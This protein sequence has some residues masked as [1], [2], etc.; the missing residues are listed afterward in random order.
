[1]QTITL[2]L[3]LHQPTKAKQAV[4]RELAVRV[5]GLANNLV[6][7]GRP[8][9][10]TSKTAKPYCPDRIPSA[11]INQALRDAAAHPKV[12]KFRV[13]WP[14]FNNQN[15]RLERAGDFWTVG[16]PT[17]IGRVR[18]P[19]QATDRQAQLLA[20]LGATVKQGAAKLHEKRGRW[21]LALSISVQVT[22]CVGTKTAGVDLGLRNLAVVNCEGETL[23]FSGDRAAFVRRRFNALRRRMGKAKALGAIRRMKDKEARWM[24]NQDHEISRKIVDWCIARGVGT[25]RMEDLTGIRIR[26]NRNRKDRGRS[27]HSWS[28]YRL[29]QFI[30]YKANLAGIKVEWVVPANTSRTCP[31]CGI[32]D[33]A[34]RKGIRFKCIACGH[35]EHADSVGAANI[36]R[37][38]SG[39]AAA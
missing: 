3:K 2:R 39:L 17:H 38:I 24:K 31:A 4:Y 7:A 37:A 28:F 23:F 1:M 27:L 21:Y 30:I 20:K 34:S 32:A 9:K 15:C 11:V 6:A 22:P 12:E 29:K 14:G 13:L 35:A 18:V 25:I 26:G 8:K 33:Q 19:L 36:A 5:T 10:L 16:F